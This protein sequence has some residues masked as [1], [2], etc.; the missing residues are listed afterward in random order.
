M[1]TKQNAIIRIIRK[2]EDCAGQINDYYDVKLGT[3]LISNRKHVIELLN[4]RKGKL[5]RIYK[6]TP[7]YTSLDNIM[8]NYTRDLV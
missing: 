6:I 4:T 5:K 1:V 3:E 8:F 2:L 7:I